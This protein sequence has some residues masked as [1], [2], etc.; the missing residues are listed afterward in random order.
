LSTGNLLLVFYLTEASPF[1]VAN[2]SEVVAVDKLV[3]ATNNNEKPALVTGLI[4]KV[5]INNNTY[6]VIDYSS[7]LSYQLRDGKFV[8]HD[9]LKPAHNENFLNTFTGTTRCNP[10][11]KALFYITKENGKLFLQTVFKEMIYDTTWG[12]DGK[13]NV[14]DGMSTITEDNGNTCIV[15]QKQVELQHYLGEAE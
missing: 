1:E 11:V 8:E 2:N 6:K 14:V 3:V 4:N 12:D 7:L 10:A 13:F 9:V 15:G 5:P